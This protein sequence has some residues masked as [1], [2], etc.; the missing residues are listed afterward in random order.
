[1]ENRWTLTELAALASRALADAQVRVASGRVTGV[2]DG[3]LIRWYTTIGLL[4]RPVIGPDRYARYGTRQLLQLVA[5]KRLQARGLPIAD[6]QAQL[7]GATDAQLGRVA[8]LPPG[9]TD[10]APGAVVS[11]AVVPNA[12][13][14]GVVSGAAGPEPGRSAGGRPDAGRFWASDPAPTVDSSGDDVT[15]VHGLRLGGV[16]LLL[17]VP[18]TP[19]DIEAIT[20]AARPLLDVLANRDLLREQTGN[21][22]LLREHMEDRDLLREQTEDRGP[23][24]HNEGSQS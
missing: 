16:T 14:P 5:I 9:L 19:A 20:A 11:R 12:G 21:R 18:P 6:I 17:P 23:L 8:A 3:R 15:R 22:D 24:N 13:V 4:D 1:V 10:D 2:P 7:A